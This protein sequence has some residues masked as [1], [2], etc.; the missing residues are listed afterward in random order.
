MSLSAQIKPFFKG[1]VLDDPQT[2]QTFSKDASI[3]QLTPQVVVAPQN[4]E[5]IQS[6]VRF[7]SHLRGKFSLTVRSG[8]T[9]MSG[10]AISDSIVLDMG[11]HMHN[12][13]E[14]G[15]DFAISQPGMLYR[16]FEKATLEKGL[17]LPCY[18]ASREIC[19]VGGMVANNSAGEKTLLYGQT[20]RYVKSLK[21]V[22]S[23]GNEYQFEPLSRE[24]LNIKRTQKNF[25]GE[26]YNKIYQL[27]EDNYDLIQAAKPNVHKNSAGYYLW[28]VWDRKTFDL[29]KLLVGSQGTLGI[30]TEI[31][32]RLI[33]PNQHSKLLVVF[34]NDLQNLGKIVNKILAVGPESFESYDDY[35]LKFAMRF[36]T[37]V[38]KVFKPHHL[39]SLFFQF[40]PEMWMFIKGGA[41]KLVLLAQFS[42]DSAEEVDKKCLQAQKSL[43]EFQVKTRITTSEDETK[44]YWVIRRESFNLFRHHAG[45]K[46][47]APFI[48]DFVI[49]PK[50]LP[51]F[52]P[53]L[54][55]ILSQY[56][57]IYTIAG[58]I[59]EG[60]FHII[61]LM[62]FSDPKSRQIIPELG[63][64]VYDL[65]F[66]YKGSMTGEHND[67]MVRGPYLPQ[68]YGSEI[69]Q[70]FKEVKNIFDPYNI[71][72]P[73][74]KADATFDYSYKHI[75]HSTD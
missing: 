69:Y 6:L 21:A 19:T 17:L 28:N 27:I 57:L 71:F 54:R 4:T 11:K 26:L 52:L 31:K 65:V 5:D 60:N 36:I 70:L 1:E 7:V 46:R 51:E 13:L 47:T 44:K 50:H 68:M 75:V 73:H 14:V 20:E 29:T 64:K 8:G 74:K 61:P 40:I 3:F 15:E 24:Q 37:E 53:Q 62:D 42:G 9:D 38:L 67:G 55:E 2:L 59:G 63:Q 33:K 18:P 43:E 58:H 34:L 45:H 48:D 41:P 49:K 10:G 32:F 39:I 23:D 22:L 12:L 66:Q 16:E 25:E 72:N 35:T 30:I 56:N